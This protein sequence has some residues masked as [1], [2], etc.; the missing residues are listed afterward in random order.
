MRNV[1]LQPERLEALLE[2]IG[3]VRA[4]AIGDVCLDVYWIADMRRATLS[5]ETPHFNLPVME[6]RYSLGAALEEAIALGN[7]A[8]AVTIQKIGQ[9]GTAS[10]AEIRAAYAKRG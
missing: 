4:I 10:A 7:L 3:R 6:E 8:S 9:T 2:T 5:R 1:G